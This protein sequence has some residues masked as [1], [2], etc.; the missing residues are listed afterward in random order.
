[1]PR[2]RSANTCRC[3]SPGVTETYERNSDARHIE[4]A[5][6]RE[7][8][9]T[10][11]SKS[12]RMPITATTL[13]DRRLQGSWHGKF[14]EELGLTGAVTEEQFARMAQGQNPQTR[15]AVDRAPATR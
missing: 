6:C 12:T 10:T 3:P 2:L 1:M 9:P 8:R 7:R 13:R 11:S 5:H 4:A 14:A 15:R